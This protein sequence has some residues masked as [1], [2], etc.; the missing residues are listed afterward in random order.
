MRTIIAILVFL[1]SAASLSAQEA[2]P[3]KYALLAAVR[4]YEHPAMNEPLLQF[5]E[6]DAKSMNELLKESGYQVDLLVGKQATQANIRKKLSDFA[7]KG[8]NKG[9]VVVGLFGH[10][11]EFD[12]T[13]K[14][15]F[16][17]YDTTVKAKQ[18]AEGRTISDDNGQPRMEPDPQ[19]LLAIDEFL[20]ALNE[21]KAT[22][23]ILL[24][25]C[26]RNDPNAARGRS[27]G[28]SLEINQLPKNSAVFF[29]CSAQEKAFEHKEW[30]HGAFTK[31]LLDA[32]RENAARGKSLMGSIAEDVEPAVERLVA[33]KVDAHQTPRLL[34]TG[35]RID[36]QLAKAETP[37][38]A[39]SDKRNSATAG[40]D[41]SMPGS[42]SIPKPSN[43]KKTN[44]SGK[45]A[46]AT[47]T[48]SAESEETDDKSDSNTEKKNGKPTASADGIEYVID[49]AT[50]NGA[51]VRLTVIA[52]CKTSDQQLRVGNVEAVD[53][54]GNTYVNRSQFDPIR[55]RKGVKAKFDLILGPPPSLAKGTAPPQ[56]FSVVE[57]RI[58]YAN[59]QGGGMVG[60]EPAILQ[61]ENV[62]ISK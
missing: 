21:C 28:T 45:A 17:P 33:S 10:G 3:Q 37:K 54:E 22:N 61:F 14:S 30:G 23:R 40:K 25:D 8:G 41:D 32:I 52:I 38:P 19:S 2:K 29:A 50:R 42:K 55:L 4:E 59:L 15:Y 44:A 31:C 56:E 5:P 26:C 1:T 13:K 35:A 6:I 57:L 43:G 24:A 51:Q 46:E 47:S 58:R 27:F 20:L 12:S 60:V 48:P 36:L 34:S 49:K 16:C 62:R 53:P 11:I 9:V 7:A 18:D 39:K